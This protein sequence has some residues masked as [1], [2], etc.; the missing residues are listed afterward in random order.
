MWFFNRQYQLLFEVGKNFYNGKNV[1]L[2]W[3]KIVIGTSCKMKKGPWK[4]ALTFNFFPEQPIA[5]RLSRN[6]TLSPCIPAH[7]VWGYRTQSFCHRRHAAFTFVLSC[8]KNFSS[9]QPLHGIVGQTG[10]ISTSLPDYYLNLYPVFFKNLRKEFL[11]SW[12]EPSS[13]LCI[14]RHDPKMTS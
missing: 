7:R 4:E 5:L 3:L 9:A 10:K 1:Q 8:A 2:L 12:R 6:L 14:S 11:M 13:F